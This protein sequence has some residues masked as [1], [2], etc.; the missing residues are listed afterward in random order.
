[1][2]QEATFTLPEVITRLRLERPD[3]TLIL[4]EE[5]VYL[6]T[7]L[8]QAQEETDIKHIATWLERF[9]SILRQ[10]YECDITDSE[11]FFL[12]KQISSLMNEVKKNFNDISISQLSTGSI[13]SNS[14]TNSVPSSTWEYPEQNPAKKSKPA[15]S[16]PLS[17]ETE[18][19]ASGIK[20]PEVP[21]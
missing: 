7:L 13:R 17:Q 21:M 18:S 5:V 1:M 14:T 15:E 3:G 4:A 10:K 9:G 16:I 8:A 6:D 11:A 19:I 20:L 2:S 12:A